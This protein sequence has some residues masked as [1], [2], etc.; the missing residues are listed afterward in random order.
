MIF[1]RAQYPL[2]L[3]VADLSAPDWL[4]VFEFVSAS[5]SA[6]GFSSRSHFV[7]GPISHCS[8]GLC[9]GP[10]SVLA[11]G[12]SIVRPFGGFTMCSNPVRLYCEGLKDANALGFG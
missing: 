7:G 2:T 8:L 5:D 12:Y 3:L 11:Q 1:I 4:A 10:T 6:S 9:F